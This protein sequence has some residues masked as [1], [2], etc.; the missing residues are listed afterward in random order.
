[1]TVLLFQSALLIAIAFVLGCIAGCV[2]RTV[3]GISKERPD[4]EALKAAPATKP[5]NAGTAQRLIAA[6]ASNEIS[7]TGPKSPARG[8]ARKEL[9]A[10]GAR[11]PAKA[12]GAPAGKDDLKRIKGIGRQNEARLN[13]LGITRSAQIAKWRKKEVE[14]WGVRLAFSGR[15]EREDWVS[16]AKAL[17]EGETTEFAARVAKGGVT[18]STGKGGV[19]AVGKRPRTLKAPRKSGADNLTLISGIGNAIERKLFSIGVF[20]FDQIA[21]WNST[22]A[23]WVGNAI[24]FPGR[25]QR[26][27]WIGEAAVLADGGTTTHAERVETG[28]VKTSRISTDVERENLKGRKT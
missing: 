17:A 27:N 4:R 6:S 21:S 2:G 25:V 10:A 28:K 1:M 8:R 24:N 15:I 9:A 20:H 11:K 12:A 7:K 22:E 19:G 14:E 26:D 18:S 5:A 3:L 23:I 16:Q 13:A